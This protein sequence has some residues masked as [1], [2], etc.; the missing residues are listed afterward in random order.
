MY[1]LFNASKKRRTDLYVPVV[2]GWT[3][4]LEYEFVVT[5]VL[6]G[7]KFAIKHL[8]RY[9]RMPYQ[10]FQMLMQKIEI[11]YQNAVDKLVAVSDVTPEGI[12][13]DQGEDCCGRF[14]HLG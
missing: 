12:G 5:Q 6:G 8:G 9:I 7:R 3:H 10:A 11:P 1:A 4:E 14:A 13:E 2:V